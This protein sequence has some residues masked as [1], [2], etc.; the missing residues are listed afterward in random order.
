MPSGPP[1]PSTKPPPCVPPP[2]SVMRWSSSDLDRIPIVH[3]HHLHPFTWHCPPFLMGTH[4]S[5]S[6][7]GTC[8]CSTTTLDVAP[9]PQGHHLQ[10]AVVHWCFR[11][12]FQQVSSCGFFPDIAYFWRAPIC[13]RVLMPS[14]HGNHLH[15]SRGHSPFLSSSQQ[16]L[17]MPL[18]CIMP[19][20]PPM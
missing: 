15:G 7:N 16:L 10:F 8:I 4:T 6:R 18:P 12:R 17:S 11:W 3:G 5:P 14:V 1:I 20:P 2:I 13:A 9:I 19:P